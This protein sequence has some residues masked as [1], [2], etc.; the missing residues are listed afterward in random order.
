M[1]AIDLSGAESLAETED[2]LMFIDRITV[3][4][5]NYIEVKL[6]DAKTIYHALRRY[7]PS[8]GWLSPYNS[9]IQRALQNRR[10]E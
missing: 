10:H 4:P 7:T 9:N 6:I 2:Y 5:E 8:T 1:Q 3:F